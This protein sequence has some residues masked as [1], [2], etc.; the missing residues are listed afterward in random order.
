M[1]RWFTD[2]IGTIQFDPTKELAEIPDHSAFFILSPDNSFRVFCYKLVRSK[3]FNVVTYVTIFLGSVL[4]TLEIPVTTSLNDGSLFCLIQDVIIFVDLVIVIYFLVEMFLKM[5][6]LGVLL[7]RGSYLRGFFNIIDFVITVMSLIPII[8]Y[9]YRLTSSNATECLAYSYQETLVPV[10]LATLRVFRVFRPMRAIRISAFY[11]VVTGLL[12]SI[13]SIGRILVIC[14]L[15]MSIFAII[16]TI[17]FRGSFFYCTDPNK[18]TERECKGHFFTYP[19]GDLS[20]P[21]LNERQWLRHGLNFDNFGQSFLTLFSMITSEGWQI[22]MYNGYNSRLFQDTNEPVG[23]RPNSSPYAFIFFLLYMCIMTLV[24]LNMFIGFVIVTF[25]EVGIK[26][27]RESKLDRNQRN[28]LYFAL[29]TKPQFRYVP[30]FRWQERLL[31]VTRHPV[32]SLFIIISL[33]CN[34]IILCLQTIEAAKETVYWINFFFTL[35]FTV[36]AILKMTALHPVNYFKNLWNFLEFLSTTGALLEFI[37]QQTVISDGSDFRYSH[38]ASSFRVLWL[39]RFVP[40]VRLIMWTVIKSLE[41]FPW[42][43]LLL[44]VVVFTFAVIGMQVFGTIKRA[45]IESSM[46][47]PGNHITQYNNFANFPQALL[48]MIRV[49]TGENWQEV[50]LSCKKNSP[51][52]SK[53]EHNCGSDATYFFY[54]FFYAIASILFLNLFVAI[55]ID[56][57]DYL[58]KDKSVL[59]A[60]QLSTFVKLWSIYDPSASGELLPEEVI[61]LLKQCNPPVGWGILCPRIVAYRKMMDLNMPLVDEK[62]TF[63]ATLFGLVKT[64]LDIGCSGCLECL[65]KCNVELKEKLR[66]LFPTCEQRILDQVLPVEDVSTVRRGYAVH[67]IQTR[68]RAFVRKRNETIQIFQGRERRSLIAGQRRLPDAGPELLERKLSDF[69]LEEH[70]ILHSPPQGSRK[71]S[72]SGVR[73][74]TPASLTGYRFSFDQTHEERPLSGRWGEF[75]LTSPPLAEDPSFSP[76]L[77]RQ[78]EF[79]GEHDPDPFEE[80]EDDEQ[81]ELS[82]S[83][84]FG[85]PTTNPHLITHHHRETTV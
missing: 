74:M 84:A 10:Y 57:F 75:E 48:V 50:M 21:E 18:P 19:T 73:T 34:S 54:P 3:A 71:S 31:E 78:N 9:F 14:V 16:G 33:I 68:W 83:S 6:A 24:L 13:K 25:Q 85:T 51:C 11:I 59:G 63:H 30:K 61:K 12:S 70:S 35:L 64:S 32:F 49:T 80:R 62:V 2:Y 60:H 28:C 27:F 55:I 43:G 67:L 5:T 29:T 38:F 42:V 53:P 44:L 82:F 52:E 77:R 46:E 23:P 66:V 72:V 22:V 7:H 39:L 37:L 76:Q 4:L 47:Y 41:I 26:A 65:H 36:E 8:S 1:W 69:E 79:S 45:P 20:C 40:Q 15:V 81:S 56:N 58:V 17:L